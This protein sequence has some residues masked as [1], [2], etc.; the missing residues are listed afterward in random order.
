MNEHGCLRGG[1]GIAAPRIRMQRTIHFSAHW[2][3]AALTQWNQTG[4]EWKRGEKP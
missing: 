2:L 3:S 4:P 1:H